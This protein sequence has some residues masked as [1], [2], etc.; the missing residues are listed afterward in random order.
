MGFNV[1]FGSNDC[2]CWVYSP[3]DKKSKSDATLLKKLDVP[4]LNPDI[5]LN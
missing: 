3:L 5:F 4:L 2:I 1:Y